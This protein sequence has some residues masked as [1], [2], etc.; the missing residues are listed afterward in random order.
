MKTHLAIA[1]AAACLLLPAAAT[2]AK[3]PDD[4]PALAIVVVE[5]LGHS[6]GAITA[7]E[8]LDM[9]FNKIAKERKWPAKPNAERFAAN[10]PDRETELRV[11]TQ[12]L[13]ND[14]PG[15]ITL[16][17]WVTLTV[18][19][20]KHDF[21]IVKYDYRPRP[22]EQFED[23]LQKVYVGGA[24]KIADKVEP[25]LFPKDEKPAAGS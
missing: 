25:L 20:R 13:R 9:A 24:A 16:R 2:A 7:V 18:D 19:G 4:R 23:T 12:P 6:G 8:R 1:L 15:E 3:E 17:A 10:T 11:F 5:N 22:G 21:G 14:V